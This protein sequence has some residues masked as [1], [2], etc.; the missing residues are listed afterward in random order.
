MFTFEQDD[1]ITVINNPAF[2]TLEAAHKYLTSIINVE[3]ECAKELL[4]VVSSPP[5]AECADIKFTSTMMD[6]RYLLL[7]PLQTVKKLFHVEGQYHPAK[8][9]YWF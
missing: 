5:W 6:S 2:A 4:I 1:G 3:E 8:G 7:N 9:F